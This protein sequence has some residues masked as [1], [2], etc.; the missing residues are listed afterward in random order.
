MTGRTSD[1]CACAGVPRHA[2]AG[3]LACR[4]QALACLPVQA[5]GASRDVHLLDIAL[6]GYFRLCVERA[7]KAALSGDD[8]CELT[9]LVLRNGIIALD[10]EDLRQ[11]RMPN[12]GVTIRAV[13]GSAAGCCGQHGWNDSVGGHLTH[14]DACKYV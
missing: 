11:V 7:D 3:R 10:S 4:C 8:L 6:D 2:C 13:A 1:P 9:A 14:Q 12:L 5:P